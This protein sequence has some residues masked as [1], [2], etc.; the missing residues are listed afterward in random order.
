M[1]LLLMYFSLL[2]CYLAPLRP[3][4]SPQHP[5]LENSQPTFF[6]QCK[7]PSFTPIQN[8]GKIINSVLQRPS[9]I[10]IIIIIIMCWNQGK[11]CG[12]NTKSKLHTLWSENVNFFY[13]KYTDI[14]GAITRKMDPVKQ[15]NYLTSSL[16][17]ACHKGLWCVQLH[18]NE[19]LTRHQNGRYR[20]VFT[21]P[22]R[23]KNL[24]FTATIRWSV[25]H[26]NIQC[27]HWGQKK[28]DKN[29]D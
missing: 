7:R 9:T 25:T 11:T 27:I 1:K 29:C 28:T 8:S 5:I 12:R 14:Y 2:P 21:F 15:G 20:T 19:L 4:Y 18:N 22:R 24:V 10:T 17:S 6:F 23:Q 26:R 13:L 3:K 16:L